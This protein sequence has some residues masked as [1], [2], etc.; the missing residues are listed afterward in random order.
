MAS[1]PR[2]SPSIELDLELAPL[3]VLAAGDDGVALPAW[4]QALSRFVRSA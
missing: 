2:A 1:P 3:G 4:K